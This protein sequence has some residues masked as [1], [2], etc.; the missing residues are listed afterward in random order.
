MVFSLKSCTFTVTVSQHESDTRKTISW[1]VT[2]YN[3][4]LSSQC[5][6]CSNRTNAGYKVFLGKPIM[7]SFSLILQSR[8]APKPTDL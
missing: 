5:T 1:S 6:Y 2:V 8:S 4:N 3:Q 7:C